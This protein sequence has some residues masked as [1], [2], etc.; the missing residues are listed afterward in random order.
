MQVSRASA[1]TARA[2]AKAAP[3]VADE[4]AAGKLSL[5]Q[6]AKK[7]GIKGKAKP[8]KS[9]PA[10]TAPA[11]A[12]VVATAPDSPEPKDTNVLTPRC[13]EWLEAMRKDFPSFTLQKI[14][15]ACGTAAT[16]MMVRE[17]GTSVIGAKPDDDGTWPEE[18]SEGT[19][20]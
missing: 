13:E 3:E 7:A 16:R 11:P 6:A 12:K 9:A 5:N 18:E 15:L 8:S 17:S 10:K 4:V 2:I 20:E 14:A 19:D 1:A